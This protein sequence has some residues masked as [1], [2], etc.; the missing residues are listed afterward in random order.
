MTFVCK[1][2][3]RTLFIDNTGLSISTQGLTSHYSEVQNSFWM[4]RAVGPLM[5]VLNLCLICVRTDYNQV[6]IF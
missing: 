3:T 6:I 5:V 2:I 4:C 1:I